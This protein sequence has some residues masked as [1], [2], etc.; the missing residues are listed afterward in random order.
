M[1]EP[2]VGCSEALA[3]LHL[4]LD[5]EL[6]RSR[7][8]ELAEHLVACAP[9]GDRVEFERHVRTV[10]RAGLAGDLSVPAGLAERIRGCLDDVQT[11]DDAV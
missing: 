5:G 9:C 3:S 2:H 10:I 8:D 11:S 6:E 4:F 1:M 7:V